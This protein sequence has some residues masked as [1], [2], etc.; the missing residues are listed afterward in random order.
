MQISKISEHNDWKIYTFSH[1]DKADGWLPGDPLRHHAWGSAEEHRV[2]S[3]GRHGKP[4]EIL[5]IF[6]AYFDDCD[7]AHESIRRELIRRIARYN[8]SAEAGARS[9]VI[10][11]HAA[12]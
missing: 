12:R 3:P 1:E 8:K 2:W 7:T 9:P 10:V 4:A 6:P 11:G 5:K